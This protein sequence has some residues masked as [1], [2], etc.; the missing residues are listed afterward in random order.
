MPLLKD[1]RTAPPGGW[2]Y[3]QPQTGLEMKAGS[4]GELIATVIRHRSY[5]GIAPM[6]VDEVSAEIQRQICAR[7]GE[8]FS[9][10]EPA[11]G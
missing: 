11:G 8:E 2:R 4:L 9:R 5:K 10:P 7:V 1:I 3:T 6:D